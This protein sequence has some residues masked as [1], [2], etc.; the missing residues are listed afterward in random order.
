MRSKDVS[1]TRMASLYVVCL[2]L[3]GLAIF[4]VANFP[5]VHL[6]F[7]ASIL[8]GV[9]AIAGVLYSVRLVVKAVQG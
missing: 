2:L 5:Q 8:A 4:G 3:G 7:G 9:I 6:I 1:V